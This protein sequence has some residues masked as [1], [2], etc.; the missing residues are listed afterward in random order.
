LSDERTAA[1]QYED[2]IV[3]YVKWRVKGVLSS[4]NRSDAAAPMYPL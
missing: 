3:E 1:R 4:S 2:G